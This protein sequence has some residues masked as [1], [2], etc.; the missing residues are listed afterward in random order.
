MAPLTTHAQTC[1]F[2]NNETT[3]S[4]GCLG[5]ILLPTPLTYWNYSLILG[6]QSGHYSRLVDSAFPCLKPAGMRDK[7]TVMEPRE[8]GTE[9]VGSHSVPGRP[10]PTSEP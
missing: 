6:L 10:G 5:P 3:C 9:P 4:P 1:S 2:W 8:M 7:D